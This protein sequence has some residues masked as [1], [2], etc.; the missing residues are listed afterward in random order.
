MEQLDDNELTNTACGVLLAPH[1]GKFGLIYTYF[2][3]RFHRACERGLMTAIY[4]TG[5]KV[6]V[7]EIRD[8]VYATYKVGEDIENLV[9]TLTKL[10]SSPIVIDITVSADGVPTALTVI[11]GTPENN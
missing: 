6:Q 4:V 2:E 5:K 1:P 3:E 8:G 9:A 7:S 11:F 10:L